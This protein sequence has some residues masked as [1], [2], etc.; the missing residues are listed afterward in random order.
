MSLDCSLNY[1]KK[2]NGFAFGAIIDTQSK[3]ILTQTPA[4]I[5]MSAATIGWSYCLMLQTELLTQLEIHDFVR[6]N[7]ITT[8][9]YYHALITV[10]YFDN[11]ILYAVFHRNVPYLFVQKAVEEAIDC[12]I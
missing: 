1:L 5:E 3:T 9:T 4:P 7:L 11:V 8:Q 10:P 12:M 2:V 6:S